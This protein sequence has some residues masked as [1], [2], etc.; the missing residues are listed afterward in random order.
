MEFDFFDDDINYSD[1]VPSSSRQEDAIV[2]RRHK[3]CCD[4]TLG[5]INYSCA[6]GPPLTQVEWRGPPRR[7]PTR[8]EMGSGVEE[9][10]GVSVPLHPPVAT[11]H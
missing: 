4:Q 9:G 7:K 10:G 8:A 5:D 6:R 2:D 1:S 11:R 3:R